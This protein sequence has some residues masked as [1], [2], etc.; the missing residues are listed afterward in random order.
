MTMA[1]MIPLVSASAD[2]SVETCQVTMPNTTGTYT[3]YQVAQAT[4]NGET[5]EYGDDAVN[6]AFNGVVSVNTTDKT[7]QYDNTNFEKLN[8]DQLRALAS[9]LKTA[10]SGA[11]AVDTKNQGE[12]ID[13]EVGYYI[14]IPT[15]Q[16]IIAPLLFEVRDSDV[17]LN[18][19]GSD[20]PFDKTITKIDGSADS[21][22]YDEGDN[23]TVKA[24]SVVEYTITTKFPAYYEAVSAIDNF[25]ITDDPAA[26]IAIDKTNN[27]EKVV[28]KA[29]SVTAVADT[30][31]TIA[32]AGANDAGFKITFKDAF[33]LA[34][35]G[36]DVTVTFEAKVDVSN[37]ASYANGSASHVNN[38]ELHYDNDFYTNS[39]D[40]DT[41]GSASDTDKAT[42]YEA[43]II[44]NKTFNGNT[45]S[46]QTT[47]PIN[48]TEN[49][50]ATFKLTRTDVPGYTKEITVSDSDWVNGKGYQLHFKGLQAGTYKLE[51][52][53]VPD[54]Y[55]KAQDTTI[56][57][58]ASSDGSVVTYKFDGNTSNEYNIDNKKGTSLPFTGGMGTV[59]FT[60]VGIGIV[61]LAG[62]MFVIYMKKRRIED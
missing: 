16:Q 62:V 6:D 21:D 35:G 51:E 1:L 37:N 42:V 52:T 12:S 2:D 10:T 60:V 28:V 17:I 48:G 27:F 29:A 5:Y 31:Y 33:V 61:L 55:K 13:L 14:V 20:I 11:T 59:I 34:H 26:G 22:I 45:S 43:E 58:T 30:D 3:I 25:T 8:N 4:K 40:S 38:A 47:L 46:K 50:S 24:G 36:E 44:V 54:G 56:K 23:G 19:K 15:G 32:N 9:D 49:K 39:T 41:D 57:I 7:L 18:A 53:V